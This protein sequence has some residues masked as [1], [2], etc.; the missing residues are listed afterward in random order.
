MR[1]AVAYRKSKSPFALLLDESSVDPNKFSVNRSSAHPGQEQDQKNA[2]EINK[3]VYIYKE[4]K[5][6][7]E[8]EKSRHGRSEPTYTKVQGREGYND[9]GGSQ[10]RPGVE[11]NK[12]GGIEVRNGDA[13]RPKM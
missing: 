8:V 9:D 13:S 3:D 1:D 7:K 2:I 5:L 10:G 6:A 12:S 11:R 4:K